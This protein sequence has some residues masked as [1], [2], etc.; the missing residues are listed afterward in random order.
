VTSVTTPEGYTLKFDEP[1][2]NPTDD[3]NPWDEVLKNATH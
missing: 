1:R 3:G 2:P